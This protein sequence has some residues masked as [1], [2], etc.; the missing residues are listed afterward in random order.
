MLTHPENFVEVQSGLQEELEDFHYPSLQQYAG[1]LDLSDPNTC[2]SIFSH[3]STEVKPEMTSVHDT[4]LRDAW[5]RV[6]QK[7]MEMLPSVEALLL[8]FTEVS[9]TRLTMCSC[10]RLPEWTTL[11]C[12]ISTLELSSLLTTATGMRL[13]WSR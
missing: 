12:S 7:N 4:L 11:T 5:S 9:A 3:L 8:N 6:V 13:P 1:A 10:G 2:N